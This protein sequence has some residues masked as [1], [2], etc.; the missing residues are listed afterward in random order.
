[1]L[2]RLESSASTPILEPSSAPQVDDFNS[3]I[4]M[5]VPATPSRDELASSS[6]NH[7][8][9]SPFADPP[10]I[11]PIVNL[12]SLVSSFEATVNA[13]RIQSAPPSSS[14]IPFE[15]DNPFD[16]AIG[17]KASSST[18]SFVEDLTTIFAS[19][20]ASTPIT[21]LSTSQTVIVAPA[22]E[23][24]PLV[25]EAPLA[26][27]LSL[28]GSLIALADAKDE[29]TQSLDSPAST[30][31][32]PPAALSAT[33]LSD[34][35]VTDGQVFPPG[36]EFVKCWR[37]MNDSARD[38]P[39][40]TELAFVSGESLVID[41]QSLRVKVGSV[42]AGAEADLWTGELKAPDAPG[43]YVGYWRLRD[44]EGQMFGNSIWIEI[45]VAEADNSSD[46]SCSM[47]ASSMIMMPRVASGSGASNGNSALAPASTI[48]GESTVTM[49]SSTEDG[50]G[51]NSD[52]DSDVS[53]VD[54]I[55]SEDEDEMGWEDARSHATGATG[56][57]TAGPAA[58]A[59]AT[60]A[61]AAGSPGAAG[62]FVV[63]YEDSSDSDF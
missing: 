21:P 54:L 40:G 10:V 14:I 50:D 7:E 44:E 47:S 15:S 46:D 49:R 58:D 24:T 27:L 22:A 11:A 43:R 51:A 36:A 55:T 9:S 62:D 23:S 20:P 31:G 29:E 45:N 42:K 48:G 26:E 12:S 30:P 3:F 16:S 8:L 5:S 4:G 39:E 13:S 53:L 61:A 63:L 38:W 59:Q 52:V 41:Q 37:M 19:R 57:T 60:R 17:Q 6:R 32:A 34:V 56:A 25:K 28:N 1:M 2:E 18:P 35:T 33:F